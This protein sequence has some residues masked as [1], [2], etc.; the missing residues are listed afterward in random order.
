MGHVGRED[1]LGSDAAADPWGQRLAP[2]CSLST[3]PVRD[4]PS[5]PAW[6]RAAPCSI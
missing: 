5:R 2:P 6:G 1:E 3:R 4:T